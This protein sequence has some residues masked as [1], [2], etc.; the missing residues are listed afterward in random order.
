MADKVRLLVNKLKMTESAAGL[1]TKDQ[2][3]TIVEDQKTKYI[4]EVDKEDVNFM[5]SRYGAVGE[6]NE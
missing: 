2:R 5:K 4:I 6:L 1:I 3:I